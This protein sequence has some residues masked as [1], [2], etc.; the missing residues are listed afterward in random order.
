MGNLTPKL[1]GACAD[2]RDK[3]V[4][5]TWYVAPGLS[6]DEHEDLLVAGTEV[7]A[8]YPDGYSIEENF[9]EVTDLAR[10]LPTRGVFVLLQ[11]GFDTA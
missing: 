6:E 11:R 2:L 3:T 7:I 5:L 8:D 1:Y 10:P 9:V 4:I